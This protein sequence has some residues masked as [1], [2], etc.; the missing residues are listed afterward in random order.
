MNMY[1]REKKYR[2][3]KNRGKKLACVAASCPNEREE[4]MLRETETKSSGIGISIV[5]R[6]LLP[7]T[8]D[9]TQ[10]QGVKR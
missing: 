7:C 4:E 5:L 1:L 3:K 6:L 9:Q 8:N 10:S 2:A